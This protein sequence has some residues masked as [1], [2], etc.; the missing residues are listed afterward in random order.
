M[1]T[2]TN[3]YEMAAW[4]ATMHACLNNKN[5]YNQAVLKDAGNAADIVVGM[6]RSRT[7]MAVRG[8]PKPSAVEESTPEVATAPETPEAKKAAE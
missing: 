3:Q 6:F 1:I 4:I 2:L 8:E 7:P 5:S